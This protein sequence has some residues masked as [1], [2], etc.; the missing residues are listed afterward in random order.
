VETFR[1]HI[2]SFPPDAEEV[3]DESYENGQP[4]CTKYSLDGECLGNRHWSENG[5]LEAQ[6]HF[7]GNKPHVA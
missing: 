1:H 6:S 4:F 2:E 5:E 7:R 3:V